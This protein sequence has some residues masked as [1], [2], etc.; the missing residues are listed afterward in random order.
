MTVSQLLRES[1]S[2]HETHKALHWPADS[3]TIR[4]I[5][6]SAT[7]A[8]RPAWCCNL[9]RTT[10]DSVEANRMCCI[11]G[12][13]LVRVGGRGGKR[14]RKP[15]SSSM[16]QTPLTADH[17]GMITS[18]FSWEGGEEGGLRHRFKIKRL[19]GHHGVTAVRETTAR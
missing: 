10:R 2:V 9:R 18:H 13:V 19:P 15:I 11:S 12:G 1:T 4:Q 17:L 6:M 7:L 16:S 14:M 3:I 8:G 5:L